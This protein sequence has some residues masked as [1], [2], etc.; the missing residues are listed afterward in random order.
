MANNPLIRTFALVASCF[1]LTSI[2]WLVWVYHLMDVVPVESVDLASQVAGYLAQA[3]G[4]G[5][6]AAVLHSRRDLDMRPPTLAAIALYSAFLVPAAT[7]SALAEVLALGYLCNIA[8]GFIAA[9]YL[10]CLTRLVPQNRRGTVFGCGYALATV[11]AWPLSLL[12]SGTFLHS[13]NALIGCGVLALLAFY[14]VGTAY[15]AR[16]AGQEASA[17]ANASPTP[18]PARVAH[19]TTNANLP[20]G[21]LSTPVTRGLIALAA[22]C[23][24]LMCLVKSLGNGFPAA[25]MEAGID[26]ELSRL[27]YAGGLVIAGVVSDRNRIYGMICC[28]AALALPFITL[29]LAGMS[30]PALALWSLGYFLFGFFAV[31]RVVLFADIAATT[32]NMVLSGWGLMVGRVGDALGAALC[33][34]LANLPPVLVIVTALLFSLS[35]FLCFWLY[36]RAYAT[37]PAQPTERQVFEAFAAHHDLSAREREVLRLLLAEHSNSEIATT[38]FVSESTVKFHVRNL[39]KKTGCANRLELMAIYADYPRA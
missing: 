23:I 4:I 18:G 3:V 1:L 27:F 34:A 21:S 29:A 6:Y 35:V 37:Q 9:F 28:M 5:I 16:V 22:F 36:H 26:L 39:L 12:D 11:L 13:P 2:G 30:V 24:L 25:D 19:G 32:Q 7:A 33:L 10:H 8:C 15:R 17:V 14:C 31:F 20:R 38:L